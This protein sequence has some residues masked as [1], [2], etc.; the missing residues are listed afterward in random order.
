MI[1][2]FG[3]D[4]ATTK[5]VFKKLAAMVEA[6]ADNVLS[7]LAGLEVF[8]RELTDLFDS[9]T[10]FNITGHLANNVL[11]VG[12]DGAADEVDDGTAQWLEP[13]TDACQIKVMAMKVLIAKLHG[14][15]AVADLIEPD[16]LAANVTPI[17]QLLGRCC[18]MYGELIAVDGS[19][20]GTWACDR[21]RLRLT[22]ATGLFEIL[23]VPQF[24][25][26]AGFEIFHIAAA[27][28]QDSCEE[29]R[30]RL[31]DVVCRL[32]D[33]NKI[34][35]KHVCALVLCAADPS[36]DI[37]NKAKTT[38]R[39]YIKSQRDKLR[40]TKKGGRG[41]AGAAPPPE[42]A[43]PYLLL[44]LAHHQD[45]NDDPKE[46]DDMFVS[47]GIAEQ[48]RLVGAM[49]PYLDFFLDTACTKGAEGFGFLKALADSTRVLKDPITPEHSEPLHFVT[50]FAIVV[51]L[52]RAR[53]AKLRHHLEDIS[54]VLSAS[55]HPSRAV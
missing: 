10:D 40:A 29:V 13:A 45:Y 6:E 25:E 39:K 14:F 51:I 20:V 37:T 44:I 1:N 2:I 3:E 38:L 41:V 32:A 8:A 35:L 27:I 50:E 22:A 33:T 42:Y 34:S 16:H 52:E 43:L 4:S 47:F 54:F 18:D 5:G 7:A 49:K 11:L 48:L 12:D 26:L 28:L 30:A 19:G 9:C 23:N 55:D 24:A 46:Y 31:L 21:S 17:I 36:K 15:A 53:T